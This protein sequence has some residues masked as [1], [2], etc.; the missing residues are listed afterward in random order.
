MSREFYIL[1][2]TEVETFALD[3]GADVILRKNIEKVTKQPVEEGGKPDT[4]WECDEYQCRTKESVTVSDV[5]NNFDTWWTY[6]ENYKKEEK[7]NDK[8]IAFGNR[9][10]A[11]EAAII[12]LAEVISNG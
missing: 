3:D 9:I 10:D 5:V 6:A 2:P 12:E 7:V 8:E 11:I 4:V 1:K